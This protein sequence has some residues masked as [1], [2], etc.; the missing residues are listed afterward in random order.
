MVWAVDP[1]FAGRGFDGWPAGVAFRVLGV[2]VIKDFLPE[3]LDCGPVPFVH[4]VWG[5][6]VQA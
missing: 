2:V 4:G 3:G 5:V 6:A 1:D